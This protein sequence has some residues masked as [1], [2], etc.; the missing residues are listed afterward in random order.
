MLINIENI[1]E[2]SLQKLIEFAK[3]HE[4]K[5]S[6][7]DDEK[8]NYWLPGRPLTDEELTSIVEKSRSSGKISMEDAHS[9][10]RKNK[11]ES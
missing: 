2:I 9:I 6:F 4:M 10:I 1:N 11:N 8:N 3:A 7:I 5:L